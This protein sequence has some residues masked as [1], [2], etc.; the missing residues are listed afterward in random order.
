MNWR[1]YVMTITIFLHLFLAILFIISGC[2]KLMNYKD[3]YTTIEKLGVHWRLLKL[4]AIGVPILEVGSASLLLYPATQMLAKWLILF[5]LA[6]FAWSIY[7]AMTGK[8]KIACNCFG[9]L[10]SEQFGWG[11]SFRLALF[12]VINLFLLYSGNASIW[13]YIS[14]TEAVYAA[15]STIGLLFIYFLVPFIVSE[16]P[17]T[18]S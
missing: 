3:I 5:L 17:Y 9:S 10:S 2:A 11:T 8:K 4:A 18:N 16:K 12:L 14:W 15:V 7:R 6:T 1:T 13:E